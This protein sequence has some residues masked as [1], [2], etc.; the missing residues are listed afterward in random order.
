MVLRRFPTNS[1]FLYYGPMPTYNE[2]LSLKKKKV[3]IIWNL[4]KELGALARYEKNIAPEVIRGNVSDY[5][6][7]SDMNKFMSQVNHVAAALKAG[8]KVFVHCH[9]G[10]GRTGMVLAALKIAVDKVDPKKALKLV[11][12]LVDGPD[13]KEQEEFVKFYAPYLSGEKTDELPEFPREKYKSNY[14]GGWLEYW[15]SKGVPGIG[16]SNFGIPFAG[17]KDQEYYDSLFGK[18]PEKSK[19]I[20]TKERATNPKP[21]HCHFCNDPNIV[22]GHYWNTSQGYK[23]L[24]MCQVCNAIWRSASD[25]DKDSWTK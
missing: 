3:D 21:S 18:Q 23:K 11:D 24:Y 25:A 10:R 5:S 13:T 12:S 6:V 14:G 1:G 4:A 2:L 22:A 16:Q 7:P 19:S 15:N 17:S 9:G 20:Q 8:K